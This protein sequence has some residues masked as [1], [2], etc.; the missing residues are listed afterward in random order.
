M[1]AKVSCVLVAALVFALAGPGE[2]SAGTRHRLPAL[3]PAADDGL[4]RALRSGR[5]SKAEYALERATSLFRLRSVRDR[6]QDVK[7]P[8]P[9]DATFLLR[10]LAARLSQLSADDRKRAERI[11]ARP[12]DGAA[13]P[14]GHGY[15]VPEA[16]PLC[17]A[18]I[19]LHYVTSTTDAPPL[20]DTANGNGVP[21]WVETAA[22]VFDNVWAVEKDAFGYRAPKFDFLSTTNGGD[23]RL[24][25]YLSQI[26]DLGAFGYCTTDDPDADTSYDVSAY[27]VV[28]DDFADF[29][30]A[31]TP[32]EFL[33]VTAAHEFFHA[34]Q[35]GYDWL[36]DLWLMEGT[37]AWVEDEVYD[38]VN[39]NRRFLAVA[40]SLARPEIPVDFGRRG[41]QYGAWIFWRYLSERFGHAIVREAWERADG[42]AL[43]PDEYSLR[44][45]KGVLAA[46]GFTFRGV[47]GDFGAANRRAR[48]RYSEG[49]EGSGYP[50]PT[51]AA[52]YTLT[53][54]WRSTGWRATTLYHLTNR[55][56]SFVP[57][58][59]VSSSATLRVA[60][61]LP[62][63]RAGS[64]A[65]LL[66]FRTSGAVRVRRVP[67]N[68]AGDG[69]IRVAF[70]RGV[71]SRVDLVLTNAST[72]FDC[73]WDSAFSCGGLP[74]DD[75]RV[76]RFRARL[77]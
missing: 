35:Y 1:R 62:L 68:A 65:T 52:R 73:W 26:G 74:L 11:L 18:N 45:V 16:T 77:G 23:A 44:A 30:T 19:C 37:A 15:T 76:F 17:S 25:V 54:S 34:V 71:V 8:D 14:I 47:F 42:S 36:E 60:L 58:G 3:V 10:D 29:G 39:D 56:F 21:D 67:L 24:D 7:R 51:A 31:H 69:A 38:L 63:K 46:R 43:G 49:S 40:S 27:C 9:H 13:D 64:S 70:G 28:D 59:G 22:A 33:E 55:Y 57:G 50:T 75:R 6:F 2:A 66:V 4:A 53:S 41:F 5:I 48:T 72:R 12:S 61:D 20:A 32:Q